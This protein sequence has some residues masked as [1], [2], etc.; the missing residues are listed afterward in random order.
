MKES[1]I[2]SLKYLTISPFDEQWGLVVTT[3]GQQYI[4]PR[5]HYPAQRHPAI[6]AFEPQN[7][8]V[9]HEYQLIYITEGS[10]MFESAS[11]KKTRIEAG[12][13]LFLYPGEWHNYSPDKETGWKEL[14]IGFKG[15]MIDQQIEAGFFLKEEAVLALGIDE[16][17]VSLYKE[18]IELAEKEEIGHQQIISGIVFHLLGLIYYANK[19]SKKVGKSPTDA[20][21]HKARILM[22]E[23]SNHRI[24]P[25]EI[26]QNLGVGYSWFRQTFKQVTGIS[27]AQYQAQLLMRKAKELLSSQKYNISEVAF[28]LGFD[29]AGQ[30]STL[31]RKKEGITPTLFIDKCKL[32]Y[33]HKRQ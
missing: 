15:K 14:W 24:T 31:F 25:R 11:V 26:A 9:L 12:D 32:H 13:L 5:A 23:K 7:G 16:T 8:R 18:S 10:G 4:V 2:D 33:T 20:I 30:F 21:I 27:P 29:N 28:L 6:Y 19:N 3:V 22:K 17:I 1:N